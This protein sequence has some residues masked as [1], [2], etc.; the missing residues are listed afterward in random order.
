MVI[1]H[2]YVSLPEDKCFFPEKWWFSWFRHRRKS[3]GDMADFS[4]Q[5]IGEVSRV[6]GLV[7]LQKLMI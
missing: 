6:H 7:K 2:S 4:V 5:S 3:M 1:F